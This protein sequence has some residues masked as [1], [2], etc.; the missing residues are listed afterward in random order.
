MSFPTLTPTSQQSAIVLP[1]TGSADDVLTSLPFGI[2]TT[3]SFISGAVDQVA[4]TY[5]KLGGDILMLHRVLDLTNQRDLVGLMILYADTSLFRNRRVPSGT[6]QYQFSLQLDP[7]G[8]SDAA[9]TP[10]FDG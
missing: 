6:I 7:I 9:G 4:Y 1:S 2:Y 3:G 8:Q 5:R 10:A